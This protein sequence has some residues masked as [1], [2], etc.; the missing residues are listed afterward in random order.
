MAKRRFWTDAEMWR[1]IALHPDM[2]NAQLV[3]RVG[4]P[5]SSI[6]QMAIAL[7][8]HKSPEYLSTIPAR[9]GMLQA[10]R[11][12][13]FPKG[14]V[15][16][17]AGRKGWTAGGRAAET[18]FKKGHFPANRDPDFYVI[19]A[20]RVNTDGYIDMRVSFERGALGWRALHRI[21]WQDAHGPI[22]K[23]FAVRFK[24]GDRLNVELDNLDLLSRG[25]LLRRNSIHNF[26][27]VLRSTIN[28][29]GRLKRRIRE[30]QDG[31]PA[32]SPVRHA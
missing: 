1:L 2:S 27:P 30:K 23:G 16:W 11:P 7:G 18:R 32:Q 24:D 31:R 19:G 12:F 29:L 21:L 20:L 3:T 6:S 8:L 26:P 14:N 22:P 10:G 5:Y 9:T 25:D 17:T 4:H 15:P 13:R 28:A